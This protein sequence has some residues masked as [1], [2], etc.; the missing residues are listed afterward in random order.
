MSESS[1]LSIEMNLPILLIDRRICRVGIC[2]VATK[3]DISLLDT[4]T[5]LA[6]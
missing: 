5:I 4:K 1:S 6:Y 2:L 3:D